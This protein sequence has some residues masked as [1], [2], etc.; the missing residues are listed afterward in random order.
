MRITRRQLRKI[1]RESAES[2]RLLNETKPPDTRN[3]ADFLYGHLTNR[4][5][6][7]EVTSVMKARKLQRAKE[8]YEKNAKKKDFRISPQGLTS[9]EKTL[10]HVKIGGGFSFWGPNGQDIGFDQYDATFDN[11]V[12]TILPSSQKPG[13]KGL[14]KK[15]LAA[16]KRLGQKDYWMNDNPNAANL[17]DQ[18][19]EFAKTIYPPTKENIDLDDLYEDFKEIFD[20]IKSKAPKKSWGWKS[21]R[22]GL[23]TEIFERAWKELM[24]WKWGRFI[25]KMPEADEIFKELTQRLMDETDFDEYDE[26]EVFGKYAFAPERRAYRSNKVKLTPHEDN[27]PIEQTTFDQLKQHKEG[28]WGR[29]SP[30]VLKVLID[31]QNQKLYTDVFPGL[32]DIPV[33][34]GMGVNKSFVENLIGK[35][36]EDLYQEWLTHR[37]DSSNPE[38]LY[39][40][41]TPESSYSI[42]GNW[43]IDLKP[44]QTVDSWTTSFKMANYYASK[45]SKG[46]HGYN[47]SLVLQ[48]DML[49]NKNVMINLSEFD[50]MLSAHPEDEVISIGPVR[51]NKV[52]IS[53]ASKK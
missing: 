46:A 3:A 22:Q 42:E 19:Y 40:A 45:S 52:Y 39:Q 27:T 44:G 26:N 50:E 38:L 43:T 36:A 17:L 48:C 10:D 30:E 13:S 21:E 2:F 33:Y 16:K 20:E 53:Y 49:D 32:T 15:Y 24:S 18:A 47:F 34:R 5:S 9:L 1:I 7:N 51:V 14:E 23:G 12:K 35:S 11:F 28:K 6:D 29:I 4:D 41:K 37:L 31:I 25:K 8:F